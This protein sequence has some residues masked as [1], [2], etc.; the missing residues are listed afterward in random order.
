MCYR[1]KKSPYWFVD[2]IDASGKRIRK[3]TKTSDRKEAEALEAK[4]KLEAFRQ[5]QWGEQPRYIFDQLML[6][7]LETRSK[8]K[9]SHDRDVWS[10]KKLY[11]HFTKHELV[12]LSVADIRGYIDARINAGAAAGTINRELGLFSAALNYARKWWGWKLENP[13]QGCRLPE[14][15]GRVRWLSDEEATRLVDAAA[16]SVRSPH[17]LPFVVLALS[18]GC[19][20]DEMLKLKWA[21]IDLKRKVIELAP[22]DTKNGKGRPVPLNDNALAAIAKLGAFRKEHCPESAWV[23]CR[24][25]GERLGS[26]RTAFRCALKRAKITDFR[27]HDQRHTFASW[28]VNSGVDLAYLREVLGHAS[29]RTTER[30]AHVAPDKAREVVSVV[31]QRGTLLAHP[32]NDAGAASEDAA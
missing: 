24:E 17:I 12:S 13:V 28:A 23:F 11:P 16:A 6:K 15:E 9:R 1:R 25:D 10:A 19:R 18:T 8:E 3:S 22:E 14:P 21:Q 20:R 30:Y 5:K 31:G 4:W 2:I 32:A 7:Y 26:V 27:I 29:V